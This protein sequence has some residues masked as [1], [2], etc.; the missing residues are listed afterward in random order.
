MSKRDE[1]VNDL[2]QRLDRWNLEAA[3]WEARAERARADQLDAFQSRRDE[4]LY[5]MKLLENASVAAFD[6]VA[7][8]AE[9]AWKALGEAFETAR[10]HFEKSTPHKKA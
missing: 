5:Q 9:A 2:K 3:K 6:D 7:R 4:A 8:G 1:F 10:T